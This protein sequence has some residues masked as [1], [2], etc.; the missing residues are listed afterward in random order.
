MRLAK[1]F[2]DLLELQAARVQAVAIEDTHVEVRVRA[3]AQLHRCPLCRFATRSR[4]DQHEQRWRH[5]ALGKWPVVLLAKV[6]RVNCPEH[7]VVTE[8][9]PWAAP[10]S[11][12]TLDFEELVGWMARETSR[13]AVTDLLHIA[14]RTV[15]RI[16]ERL[17]GRKLD[18]GRLDGL[19][20][21]GV[22]E[23]SYRKGHRYLTVVAD[24]ATGKAAWLG[25]GK[26]SKTLN[27]FFD[28]LGP[29]RSAKV[30]VVTMDMSAAYISTVRE[31]APQ[32]KIAFDPFHVVKLANEAV[33]E[34]RRT[35]A[36][37]RKG[38][39]QATVL[40]GS[41]WVLL[42]ASEA[43]PDEDRARLSEVAA[44]NRRVYRAYLLK[45]ELRALYR[46]RV[47][48]AARRHL[49]AWLRWARRSRLPP[50]QKLA[51]TLEGYRQGV[52]AAIALRVSNGR[53]EGLNGKIGMLQRRAFGFHSAAALIALVYLCCGPIEIT[54]PI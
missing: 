53:L 27:A 15:G 49:D 38:T 32:A 34:V 44:I 28:E 45:E 16:L 10:G 9:V 41:R 20:R 22:D 29:E 18:R 47:P 48:G 30:D 17:V 21:I 40:K 11:K 12:F 46:C 8:G 36:R 19:F 7:G 42:R 39:A 37:E 23:V 50:F 6:A 33:Q 31:R 3:R 5:L 4:Y 1:V 26:S 14:W 13:T 35:E 2:N 54:L 24:H 25:E 43:L 51:Q 52:L